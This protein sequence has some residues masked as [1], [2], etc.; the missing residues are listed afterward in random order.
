MRLEQ[1]LLC[2]QFS[3][4]T[5]RKHSVSFGKLKEIQDSSRY[6]WRKFGQKILMDE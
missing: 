6:T 1:I 5:E 2:G 3:R 4:D